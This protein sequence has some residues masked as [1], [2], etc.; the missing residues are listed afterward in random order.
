MIGLT[1]F[2]AP[3]M[4]SNAGYVA[5]AYGNGEAIGVIALIALIFVFCP[6]HRGLLSVALS[7]EFVIGLIIYHVIS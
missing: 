6:P 4:H 3:D 7:P 1:A 2:N 5:D